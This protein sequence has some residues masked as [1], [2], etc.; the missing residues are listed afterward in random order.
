MDLWRRIKASRKEQAERGVH[1]RD[2]IES[3][4]A[5]FFE[6]QLNPTAMQMAA[7]TSKDPADRAAFDKQWAKMLMDADITIKTVLY[8]AHIAG[9]IVKYLHD[10][11]PE[12]GYW[13]GK[14][15]WGQGIATEALKLFLM[16]VEVRPIGARVAKDNAASIRVLEKCGFVVA[17]EHKGFANARGAEIEEYIFRLEK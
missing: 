16:Q 17:G 1:L 10:G 15:F 2:A 11:S 8:D 7:F 12:V 5:V 13:F 3:D 14:A 6:Q 9:H 4:L